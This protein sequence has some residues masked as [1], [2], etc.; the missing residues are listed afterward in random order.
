MRSAVFPASDRHEPAGAYP[1]GRLFDLACRLLVVSSSFYFLCDNEADNDLWVHLLTGLRIAHSGA[2]PRVDDLSYTAA[3]SAWVDHEWLT[4]TAF[5]WTFESIGPTGLWLAKVGV[6]ALTAWLL[7]R[8]LARHCDTEWARAL[9]ML[10]AVAILS[11][12]F[13]MRPQI[14][15]YLGVAWLLCWVDARAPVDG[16]LRRSWTS[17]AVLGLAFVLWANGH[18]GFVF[19]LGVLTLY[20]ALPPWSGA[21][22]RSAAL[23]VSVAAA[24]ATP[25]GPSLF[26]YIGRELEFP[27]PVTE[28]QPVALTAA[29]HRPLLVLLL[30]L[31]ATL[32]FGRAV[33][34]PWRAALVAATTIMALR[35]QRHAPLLALCAAAPLAEQLG[36]A[37]AWLQSRWQQRPSRAA[38]VTLSAALLSLAVVQAGLLTRRLVA[39]GLRPVY[40][41]SE[42]PV[43]AVRFMRGGNL[44]GNVALPLDWG[45]YVLWHTVPNVKVSL[46]GRFAT[47]YPPE[48]VEDNFAFFRDPDSAG[49]SALLD[50]YPTT[51][52]L[53]PRGVVTPA[54][55][56]AGW[57]VLYRDEVAELLATGAPATPVAG[58]AA[59]G[60]LPFP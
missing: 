44:R 56:R 32:P 25:F 40:E 46:D 13:A 4:Q 30:L 57:G 2:V 38:V 7:W 33:W 55:R 52:V 19:G 47:L 34:R 49:A 31:V 51:L 42:Y 1:P 20:A 15:T 36:A 45:G 5:A 22:W 27:H 21:A 10:L 8:N 59:S 54:H 18:G 12:G 53:A 23:G 35:H 58:D 6:A 14:A 11:R 50:R 60:R 17:L 43:G 3:G 41:A 48:V 29:E 16:T 26:G 37:Q 24:C 28:W 9:A 39:D